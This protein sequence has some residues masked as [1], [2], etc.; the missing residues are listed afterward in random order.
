MRTA[1]A[2]PART[3]A[4]DPWLDF[5]Q[6]R[7]V[8]KT[9]SEVRDAATGYLASSS[10]AGPHFIVDATTLMPSLFTEFQANL[11]SGK[12]TAAPLLTDTK[13]YTKCNV[14]SAECKVMGSASFTLALV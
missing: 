14:K 4:F 5:V 8:H 13:T 9:K 6:P 2:P 3:D 12:G 1:P 11:L 10:E 7:S